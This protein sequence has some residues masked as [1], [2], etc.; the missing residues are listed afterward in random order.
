VPHR[1]FRA[2]WAPSVVLAMLAFCASA[3]A[4]EAPAA[5]DTC[6]NAAIRAEQHT[7][8]LPD[9]RAF[10]MVSPPEKNGGDIPGDGVSV[11]AASDGNAV[12]FT[13]RGSFGDTI[14]AG[15]VGQTAY[16]ARR[17]A[18]GWQSHA[19]GPIASNASYVSLGV[20]DVLDFST[21]L[22][23]AV[24]WGYD[25]PGVSGELPTSNIYAEDTLT[26]DLALVTQPL[27][28]P[29][30]QFTMLLDYAFSVDAAGV[31]D[32]AR[33]IAFTA[34]FSHLLP[35]A[36]VGVPSVYQWDDGTLRL[37]SVLPDE[38]IATEGAVLASPNED[39]DETYRQTVSPDGSRVMF[40]SPVSSE[41]QLY[42]R[43]DHE[44]TV[45][46][47][48]PETN[49]PAPTPENVV[50]QQVT[51]D[52][53]HVIFT[54]TSKLLAEDINEGPDIYMYSES[55]DPVHDFN[56][57]LVT[58]TGDVPG[59]LGNDSTAVI[60]SSDDGNWIYY[61]KNGEILTW[62]D[63]KTSLVASNLR[64]PGDPTLDFGATVSTPGA[65][66]VTL[67][68]R[69]LAFEAQLGVLSVGG[70]SFNDGGYNQVYLYDAVTDQL[71]C[72]SCPGE[73][74]ATAGT[75]IVPAVT[76]IMPSYFQPGDRPSFLASDGRTFFSTTQM[77]ASQDV[78]GVEDAYE[79]DPKTGRVSL[80][81]TGTGSQ[82]AAFVGAGQSGDDVFIVTRQHLVK[83]DHDS[84]VD[85]Y[86]VRADGGFLEP[87]SPPAPCSEEACQGTIVAPPS[88]AELGSFTFQGGD[89]RRLAP[90]ARLRVLKTSILGLRANLRI[91]APSAGSLAWTGMGVRSGSRQLAK[92]G[93]YGLSV[94]LTA[95]ARR[96]L[97]RHGSV[98]P[99]LRVTLRSPS[100]PPLAV[101]VT[102]TFG[103]FSSRKG[104]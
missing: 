27:A 75:H 18:D 94:A 45:W 102:L 67:D 37:A 5:V 11:T 83:A 81:S 10:E 95:A 97:A 73:G 100:G 86:D 17:G 84:Y 12:A 66:R 68:G 77:L 40:L 14:G 16:V 7:A 36:P 65:A 32:N 42:E 23:N 3:L 30:S 87:P 103:K 92:A 70:K 71:R 60:G 8:L 15:P 21:D 2:A 20:P 34:K 51:G 41:G 79:Y 82:P 63:G 76:T 88:A 49:G 13:S 47:S 52:G 46:I 55:H 26:N 98:R 38:S 19:V 62:H 58:N 22:R 56:L 57:T 69:Y 72:A 80:L 85:M 29:Q 44:R 35:E 53:R 28:G 4:V 33:H 61:F 9:C 101:S 25:L 74:P 43:I 89:E 59:R 6:P 78:N 48:Q 104:R 39:A 93:T 54:T 90:H 31:S 1:L 99:R 91:E 64:L 96:R 24:V 50:L